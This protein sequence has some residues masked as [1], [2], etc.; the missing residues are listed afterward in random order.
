MTLTLAGADIRGY[1][2]AL[3]VARLTPPSSP[4]IQTAMPSR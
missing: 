2:A 4:A 3:T 1:H